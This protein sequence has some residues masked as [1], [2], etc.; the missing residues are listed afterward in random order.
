MLCPAKTNHIASNSKLGSK[1]RLCSF[2]W[3]VGAL[4]A[5]SALS[6]LQWLI[7]QPFQSHQERWNWLMGN[8]LLPTVWYLN[9]SAIAK[10]RLSQQIW[11]S[12]TCCH[13]MPSWVLIGFELTALWHVT[14]NT[15]HYSFRSKANSFSFKGSVPHLSKLLI[16]LHTRY[17]RPTKG[18]TSGPMFCWNNYPIHPTHSTPNLLNLMKPYNIL[19]HYTKMCLQTPNFSHHKEPMTMQ[20]L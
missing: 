8:G 16:S 2:W 1:K 5:S 13:M 4:I 20:F 15:K 19:W 9:F 6:L 18:M 14:G 17:I 7:Y 12:W 11:L 10:D 3:T